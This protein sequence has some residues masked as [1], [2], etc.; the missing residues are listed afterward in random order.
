VVVI[1][2]LVLGGVALAAQGHEGGGHEDLFARIALA[3]ALVLLL[4]LVGRWAAVRLGQPA[5]LGELIIG[6]IAGNVGYYLGHPLFVLIMDMPEA[7][8]LFQAVWGS[9]ASLSESAIHAFGPTALEAGGTVRG[10]MDAMQALDGRYVLVAIALWIYSNIGLILLLF[11][12]GLE[13]SVAGMRSVGRSAVWV[14]VLGVVL[15]MLFVFPVL[16]LLIPDAG[17]GVHLFVAATLVA[18]SVGITARVLTDLGRVDSAEAKIILG[19]AVIDDVLGLIVLAVVVGIILTGQI[20]L[21]EMAR[22]LFLSLGFIGILFVFGPRWCARGVPFFRALD[23]SS[24]K[25]IYPFALCFSLAWLA[26]LIGL[27]AIIG[28]FI[29]GVIIEE[30]HFAKDG[31][32]GNKVR[33]L[34][35][36][37]EAVFL[38][39]FFVLM[40]MQVNLGAFLEPGTLVLGLVLIVCAILGK[41]AAGV[42]AGPDVDRL[43]IGIGMVP[44]GEVGLILANVG[45]SLG[46]IDDGLFSAIVI[47]VIV[48]TLFTPVALRWSLARR[49]A[50]A[51]T[52]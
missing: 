24:V 32:D 44:R 47:M 26:D 51:V 40:G 46:A 42:A 31:T 22:I 13:S 30:K 15:P 12:V 3:G 2:A 36:P 52:P 25:L 33:D 16:L 50:P 28:A 29:A 41:V 17:L 1:I 9:G 6:V 10:V 20:Q 39:V 49:P 7:A 11:V 21:G 35:A 27:A 34:I 4:A 37:I 14:A 43:S 5:V 48:T 8:A 18:T 45:R 23:R 38:P 19:A